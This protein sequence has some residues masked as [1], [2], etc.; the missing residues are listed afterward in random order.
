MFL[1]RH[2]NHHEKKHETA[3]KDKRC[4]LEFLLKPPGPSD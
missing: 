4:H 1:S 3:E 2:R